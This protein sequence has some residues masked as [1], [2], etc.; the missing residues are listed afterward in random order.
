MALSE[1]GLI[2]TSLDPHHTP[3]PWRFCPV[4]KM[5]HWQCPCGS[6]SHSGG[7]SGPGPWRQQGSQA[8][9]RDRWQA[10]RRPPPTYLQALATPPGFSPSPSPPPPARPVLAFG[11]SQASASSPGPSPRLS[12]GRDE[13]TASHQP[14]F[15]SR[16]SFLSDICFKLSATCPALG[17]SL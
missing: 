11:T 13:H 7:K 4:L 12:Q 10:R 2:W 5:L 6:L 8:H 3:L 16:V 14:A 15:P 17:D 1:Q 9:L